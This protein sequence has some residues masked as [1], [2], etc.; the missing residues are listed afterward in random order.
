MEYEGTCTF[1]SYS[2]RDHSWRYKYAFS[3]IIDEYLLYDLCD[4]KQRKENQWETTYESSVDEEGAVHIDLIENEPM[5]PEHDPII[6]GTSATC[7]YD[8]DSG[9][10]YNCTCH[11]YNKS[12]DSWIWMEGISH[13]ECFREVGE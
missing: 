4:A 2:L 10:R 3:D 6:W 13:E 8:D 1:Q 7:H 11:Q 5:Q 9:L 12:S